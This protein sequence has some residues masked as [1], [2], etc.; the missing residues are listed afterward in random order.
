[1]I[2]AWAFFSI[3]NQII[4][5]LLYDSQECFQAAGDLINPPFTLCFI[6]KVIILFLFPNNTQCKI[7]FRQLPLIKHWYHVEGLTKTLLPDQN[8]KL[9]RP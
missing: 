7:K 5:S 4:R 3:H 8:Y 6:T 1:M 9:H 2:L